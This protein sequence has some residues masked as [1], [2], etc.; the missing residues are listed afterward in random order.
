MSTIS[1][2]A[3]GRIHLRE[4]DDDP[5]ETFHQAL[6]DLVVAIDTKTAPVRTAVAANPRRDWLL[7]LGVHQGARIARRMLRQPTITRHRPS[8]SGR[9]RVRH[10]RNRAIPTRGDPNDPDPEEPAQLAL[11]AATGPDGIEAATAA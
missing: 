5:A 7:D 8:R 4:R 11:G 9:P 3:D 6:V 1:S 10:R 2:T